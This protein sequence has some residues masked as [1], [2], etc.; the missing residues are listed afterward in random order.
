MRLHAL[1][2]WI[3]RLRAKIAHPPSGG[4]DET[5]ET[6]KTEVLSVLAVGTEKGCANSSP[7]DTG[8]DLSTVASPQA[9]D[10]ETDNAGAVSPVSPIAPTV[11]AQVA[12]EVRFDR[13]GLA[14]KPSGAN[15]N[16]CGDC[17]HLLRR[18]TCGEPVAAGLLTAE[19]GFGIVW[20]P[21]GHGAGCP[22]FTGKMPTA[23]AGSGG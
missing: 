23:G 13:E 6:L 21:E 1:G 14:D 15:V 8:H 12:A 16:T 17:L 10:P 22:A 3:D 20:P 9:T 5:D 7:A 2:K 11:W 4:T 19:E 18:G